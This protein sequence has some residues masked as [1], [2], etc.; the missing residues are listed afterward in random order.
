MKRIIIVLSFCLISVSARAEYRAKAK[1]ISV[2]T[3]TVYQVVSPDGTVQ[4]AIEALDAWT[5]NITI[6]AMV[7]TNEAVTL[8]YSGISSKMTVD[9]NAKGFGAP[10]YMA[11]DGHLE[12]AD[13]TTNATMPCAALAMETGTGTKEV[14]LYGVTTYSTWAWAVGGLLYVSTDVGELTQSAPYSTGEQVQVVGVAIS[15]DTILFN[16]NYVLIELE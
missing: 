1:Q 2:D 14:L 6:N 4:D 5:T 12:T 11:A 16:P 7:L 15:S 8:T 3:G 10:L 9:V 13:A